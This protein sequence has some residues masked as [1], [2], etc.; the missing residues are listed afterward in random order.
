MPIYCDGG[1]NWRT[2]PHKIEADELKY[3]VIPD[4]SRNVPVNK[5]YTM[6]SDVSLKIRTPPEL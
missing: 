4:L 6:D 2:R 1:Q 3:D 5:W